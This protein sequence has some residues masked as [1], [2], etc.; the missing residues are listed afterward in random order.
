MINSSLL[1]VSTTPLR[2][3][4]LSFVGITYDIQRVA[5]KKRAHCH[6]VSPGIHPVFNRS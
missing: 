4:I 2:S 5:I 3:S 6:G 1:F